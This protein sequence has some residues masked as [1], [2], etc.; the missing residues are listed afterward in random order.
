MEKEKKEYVITYRNKTNDKFMVCLK[1]SMSGSIKKEKEIIELINKGIKFFT[2]TGPLG[3]ILI[4]VIVVEGHIKSLLNETK[5][6]NIN[7]LPLLID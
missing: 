6:D 3:K 7:E 2:Q 4:P 5:I 1:D